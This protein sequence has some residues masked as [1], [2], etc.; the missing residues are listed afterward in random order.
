MEYG[1]STSARGATPDSIDKNN[2]DD[3]LDIHSVKIKL[4]RD[5]KSEKLDFYEFK[6]NLFDNGDP[7]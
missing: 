7:D 1:D 4:C 6:M 5:L 3:K 2:N